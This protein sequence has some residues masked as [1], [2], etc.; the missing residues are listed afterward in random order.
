MKPYFDTH[1]AGVLLLI[2]LLAW[3]SMEV[4][5][6]VRQWRWRASATRI[7]RRSFWL[8]FG[9]C[10][11]VTNLAL[12][13]GPSAFPAAAIRPGAVAFAVGMVI[14]VVGIGLRGWSFHALGQYFT[15]VIKVSPDQPVVT[16]GPYRLLR[17]PSYA[18]GLLAEVGMAVTAA[19]WVS[20]AVFVVAWV[21]IIAWRIH[22]E[23]T[24]LLSALGDKYRS[25]SSHHK[26][27]IPLV[28]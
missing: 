20:A 28:W 16:N 21:A 23:E 8:G 18:G 26:R 14:M 9:A 15:A 22:I 2:V 13:L 3:L 11:I 25:Y 6:F 5:Q 12:Y 1:S 4:I 7:G 10:L 27:L 24:A 17:H 19:N